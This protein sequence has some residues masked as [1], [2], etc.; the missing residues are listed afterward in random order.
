VELPH[1]HL[2]ALDGILA[3]DRLQVH[4]ATAHYSERA[5]D[6][7]RFA[8][9]AFDSLDL[10]AS[11]LASPPARQPGDTLVP[12]QISARIGERARLVTEMAYHIGGTGFNLDVAGGLAR[13][14]ARILNNLLADLEGIRIS[15]GVVDT[16]SWE[17]EVREG[18]ARGRVRALYRDLKIDK[19]DQVTL[20][21]NLGEAILSYF[22]NNFTLAP[23]NP[24]EDGDPPEI[25]PLFRRRA[26]DEPFFGFLWATLRGGL[27]KAIGM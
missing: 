2:N 26:P 20:D 22:A 5:P 27:V 17:F 15:S 11:G 16:I 9:L 24:R 19:L 6:G 23:Q 1:E 14:D 25:M 18:L 12:I 8:L 10:V 21:Q 13:T 7:A 4:D 3:I